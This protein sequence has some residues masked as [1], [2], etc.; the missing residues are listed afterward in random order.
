MDSR[1]AFLALLLIGAVAASDVVV[2]TEDNFD[3]TING[4]EYVLVEF[5]AP[6]CGHC[7]SL[8]PEYAKAA[9][10]LKKGDTGVVLGMVDATEHR[11][12][13]SRFGVQGFP[14]LK[15]FRGGNAGDYDGP[16]KADGIVNWVKK[17]TGPPCV[18]VTSEEQLEALKE[19]N[20]VLA[21]AVFGDDAEA[22]AAYNKAALGSDSVVFAYTTD[23]AVGT[24]A[25]L[26]APQMTVFQNFD[27]GRADYTG[28]FDAASISTFVTGN[29]LPLVIPFSAEKSSEIFGSDVKTHCLIFVNDDAEA[30][31]TIAAEAAKVAKDYRGEA[32]FVTVGTDE[33][34]IS[35]FFGIEESDLPTARLVTMGGQMRKY[36]FKGAAVDESNL[37]EFVADFFAGKLVADLKS[38]DIPAS[39]DGPVTVLVGK[40]FSDI[41]LD[42]TKDVLV[43][44]YAPW[45]GHCKSL[46]P[47]FDKVGEKFANVDSVVIAKMDATA[48]EHELVEV[49]GFPTI[50]F[51][52]A[53]AKTE[54]VDYSGS[55]DEEGFVDF[56]KENAAIPFDLDAAASEEG[57]DEL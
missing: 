2:L 12:L 52:A 46:S 40:S 10:T 56:L 33:D 43:E 45:C 49:E 4:N 34:R 13:G 36:V 31:A 8:A 19:E 47:I 16:R 23:A 35:G 30:S 22:Q 39:Q 37:R 55:R 15:F 6:W 11:E 53:N 51:W 25:G 1:V 14:T 21:F 32:L 24:S 50:K 44:F 3:D 38:E 27:E 54:P 57:K 9:T 41:V 26:T 29:S 42:E 20:D 17:K 5:Y 7:K 48:N 18:T 28:E